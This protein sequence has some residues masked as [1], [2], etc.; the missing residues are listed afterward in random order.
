MKTKTL[1]VLLAALLALVTF[2]RLAAA[3]LAAPAAV[4]VKPDAASP[5]ITTLAAGT[6]PFN[7]VGVDAPAG[8]LAVAL[9]GAHEVYLRNTDQ[10]K[11][12]SPKP[13]AN[14][15]LSNKAPETPVAIA[16]KGDIA[17]V[18]GLPPGRYTKY[19]LSK[20]LI[21]YIPAPVPAVVAAPPPPPAPAVS[22]PEP[23]APVVV[24]TPP[25]TVESPAPAVAPPVVRPPAPAATGEL[26]RLFQ[27]TLVSTY[28]PL[29]PRRPY[30]WQL[31]DRNG[32]RYA[33][34]DTSRLAPGTS[35][36]TYAGRTVV[37]YGV[38]QSVAG[39]PEMVIAAE[40]L[41]AP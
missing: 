26:P 13:G 38:A 40:N 10:L 9:P 18:I 34:L 24:T 36:D 16:E 19:R 1:P 39:V 31:N 3:P 33:Y 21:G 25:P 17:E 5:V 37:I 6:E 20:P 27:G 12:N 7:A 22:Q 4:H 8:W 14:Y 30:A 35:P 23:P 11:D 29:H 15:L 41:Q 2:V 28:S 32:E